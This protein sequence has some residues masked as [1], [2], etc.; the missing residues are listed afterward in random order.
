[1]F[2][3]SINGNPEA[4]RLS[5]NVNNIVLFRSIVFRKCTSYYELRI[6]KEKL[7][8]LQLEKDKHLIFLTIRFN[9]MAKIQYF[10]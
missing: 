7:I 1:M 9:R 6:R 4:I 10:F 3:F 8:T 5:I 2:P